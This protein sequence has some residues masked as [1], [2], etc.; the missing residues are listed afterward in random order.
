MAACSICLSILKLLGFNLHSSLQGFDARTVWRGK[1]NA[2]MSL[3]FDVELVCYIEHYGWLLWALVCFQESWMSSSKMV[4]VGSTVGSSSP[5]GPRGDPSRGRSRWALT[6]P[7]WYVL[8]LVH[9]WEIR[10]DFPILLQFWGETQ[11]LKHQMKDLHTLKVTDGHFLHIYFRL[12]C[13]LEG[14]KGWLYGRLIKN[15]YCPSHSA[16]KFSSIKNQK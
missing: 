4:S 8:V 9:Q 10:S 1:D 3:W 12:S 14:S 7:R 13:W 2:W 5:W 6:A 15:N 16:R 11:N